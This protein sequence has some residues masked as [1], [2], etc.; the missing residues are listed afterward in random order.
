[1]ELQYKTFDGRYTAKFAGNDVKDLFRQ[2]AAFEEIFAANTL[3]RN[4]E[5][6]NTRLSVRDVDGNAYYER[7]CNKCGYKFAF[8]QTKKGQNLFPKYD[9]GKGGWHKW[10]AVSSDDQSEG[11]I[12]PKG[13]KK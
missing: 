7:I 13:A 1:M 8:G 6:E 10:E 9:K 4:C 5:C 2:I 12:R 11:A 3:C